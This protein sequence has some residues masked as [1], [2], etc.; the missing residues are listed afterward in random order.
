M[1]AKRRNFPDEF[2]RDAVDL[3]RSS[4]DRTLTDIA[5]PEHRPIAE[6]A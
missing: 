2:K 1:V 6:P 5:L 4:K 3:V